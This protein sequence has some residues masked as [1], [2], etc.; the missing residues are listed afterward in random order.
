[1]LVYVSSIQLQWAVG[2][3]RVLLRYHV[4]NLCHAM[5][6]KIIIRPMGS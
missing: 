6:S 4:A 2:A 3:R 5:S 1:M